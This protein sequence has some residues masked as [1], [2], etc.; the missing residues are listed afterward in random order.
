MSVPPALAGGVTRN[1]IHPLTQVVLTIGFEV[2][3][4][5]F[6]KSLFVVGVVVLL[7]FHSMELVFAQTKPSVSENQPGNRKIVNSDTKPSQKPGLNQ[8][9]RSNSSVDS[10]KIE[11]DPRFLPLKEVKSGMKG[12]ARTIFQGSQMEE[13]GVEV[14]GVL[15]GLPTPTQSS[16]IIRLSGANAERTGVFA[17][18]SG[19]P[20]FIN[21]K[22]V[23]AIAFSFPFSKEPLGG[24][25]PIEEM[26]SIFETGESEV[27]T[28]RGLFSFQDLATVKPASVPVELSQRQT[29][30]LIGADAA[31]TPS[32]A[33]LVGQTMMPIA[34][35]ISVSG[36]PSDILA[37][38]APQFEALGFRLVSG[39]SGAAPMGT[40]LKPFDDTTLLPGST[41]SVLLA[42]G[43]FSF[44][45]GGTVT[46][47]NGDQVYAFGHPFLNFGATQFPMSEGSVV[48]VV[49]NINNS[50][51]LT[52]PGPPVGMINQD[53][54][55]AIRGQ[56]G[57]AAPMIPITLNVTT[58]RGAE[59]TYRFE[60]IN[61]SFLTPLLVSLGVSSGLTA[62][63][64]ALGD[65]TLHMKGQI[66]L[67]GHAPID[68]SNSFTSRL[69]PA[70]LI[71]LSVSQP[72]GVLLGTGFEDVT[73][74]GVTLSVV[75][76]DAR[77]NGSLERIWVSKTKARRGETIEIQAFARNANGQT[78]VE[79]IPIEIPAD[80]RPGMATISVGDG[81]TIGQSE[82]RTLPEPKDTAQLVRFI[83][84]LRKN[85][86]LYVR[87]L[88][89]EAGAVVNNEEMPSLPPSM[90]ATLSS[91]RVSSEYQPLK[92]SILV[93]KE[94]PSARFL[95]TGQQSISIEV[96]K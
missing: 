28:A 85:N 83:N 30:V 46:W 52:V 72:L 45:A 78:F 63:E 57:Q 23:G 24:V 76:S 26:L 92:N 48:T 44:A 71:G 6:R 53:R 54:T 62:T 21:G 32:L 96:V 51:K 41:I 29:P 65:L 11:S 2:Q 20:V 38:Y 95:I 35:P 82:R 15:Y 18:M 50:F 70:G 1:K 81:A 79:R 59:R 56:L 68:L 12:I 27:H 36:V 47:R 58:S 73:I 66:Q 86:R 3:S 14:L 19:S 94:L 4:M 40:G 69:N 33:P 89:A 9:T 39:L 80:A 43:D 13:F 17:G 74:K 61:D 10:K 93:E 91:D 8:L 34:T 67:E 60:V 7:G 75:A 42:G 77:T 49:P 90:L 31:Y 37:Q 25:T 84:Q 88:R 87:L 55:T 22:L 16:I 64:R 5:S